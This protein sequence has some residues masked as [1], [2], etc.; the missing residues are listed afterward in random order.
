LLATVSARLLLIVSALIL[1]LGAS[2]TATFLVVAAGDRD[3]LWLN[4]ASR[5]RAQ[6]HAAGRDAVLLAAAPEAARE[7]SRE[8]LRA[9]ITEL[10]AIPSGLLD[11]GRVPVRQA[12]GDEP[13]AHVEAGPADRELS[14]ALLGL[15]GRWLPVRAELLALSH[16]ATPGLAEAREAAEATVAVAEAAGAVAQ[17]LQR[18]A[19]ERQRTLL[20]VHAVIL[21]AGLAAALIGVV[22][23]RRGVAVPLEQLAVAADAMSR[24]DLER[25]VEVAGAA[26][27]E[28]LGEAFERLRLALRAMLEHEHE[29][30]FEER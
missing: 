24:G 29:Q 26:E 13:T 12:S 3:P 9:A 28:V 8:R 7:A 15:R 16:A 11:G 21:I 27:V 18:R 4:V 10:D 30:G 2:F 17:L 23:I 22:G 19:E 14:A 1:A 5:L 20:V 6:A 25:P